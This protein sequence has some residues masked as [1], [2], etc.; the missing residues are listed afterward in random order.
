MKKFLSKIGIGF[1]ISEKQSQLFW[2]GYID[3]IDNPEKIYSLNKKLEKSVDS[4][5]NEFSN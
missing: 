5:I 2:N 4:K 1:C 3:I